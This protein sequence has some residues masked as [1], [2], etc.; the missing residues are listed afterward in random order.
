MSTAQRVA[1]ADLEA[2]KQ[3]V[4]AYCNEAINWRRPA[5]AV[6]KYVAAGVR[7]HSPHAADGPD[8]IV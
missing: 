3:L 5:E 6:A 7:H 1:T 8:A 4:V 2:N